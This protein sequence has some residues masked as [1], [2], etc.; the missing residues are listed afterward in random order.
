MAT[1]KF[2]VH[3]YTHVHVVNAQWSHCVFVDQ[4]PFGT[5][6]SV[7][8]SKEMVSCQRWLPTVLAAWEPR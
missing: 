4:S 2:E 3:V 1:Y 8:G 7:V 6:L 5:A